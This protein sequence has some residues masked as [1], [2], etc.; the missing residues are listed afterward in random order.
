MQSDM[1][2]NLPVENTMYSRQVWWVAY[3]VEYF[4]INYLEDSNL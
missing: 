3:F 4:L 2:D 1:N